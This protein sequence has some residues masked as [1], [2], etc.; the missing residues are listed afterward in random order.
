MPTIDDPFTE[1]SALILVAALLGVAATLLRQPLIVA[2]IIVGIVV[3][4]SAF[5]L[6]QDAELW[7][8]LAATGIS[9]LLFVVGLRLDLDE[10]RRTGPVAL[11]TGLGQVFFTSVVGYGIATLL[12]F[13]TIESLYIAVALTFSS[14]II[15]VKLLSDKREIDSLHGRIAVGFLIVQDIVV[16]LV[17]IGIS[18]F[19]ASDSDTGPWAE[20]L[21]VVVKGVALLGGVGLL[22]RFV[23]PWIFG[24]LAKSQELLVLGAVG[25]AMTMALTGDALGFSKE[26]GAFLAGVALASTPYRDAIGSRLAPLRDFLLLFFFITLGAS[27][28]L[29]L[30]GAQIV[31]AV[32]LSVFVLVGN[33]LIVV[34]IM[35]YMGYRRRTGFLAGLTVAQIS[36]F[37]LILGALGVAIGHIDDET[38]GLITLVGLITIGLS[39]YL[40]LYSHPI[41]DRIEG[42]LRPFERETPFREQAAER[43][44]PTSV[45]VIVFGIGRYG[46]RIAR[47]LHQRG[48]TVLGVDFDPQVVL[49]RTTEDG[50]AAQYGDAEDPE[51]PASLPLR[52]TRW[53]ISSLPDVETNLVLLRFLRDRGYTESIWLTAHH[54]EDTAILQEAG[55]D[56]VLM[57]FLDAAER[58]A[59]RIVASVHHQELLEAQHRELEDAHRRPDDR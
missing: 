50:F 53:V 29:D 13:S 47:V 7:E 42:Y 8:V 36:E 14:T 58:A 5:D 31:P 27:L 49:A 1:F 35:G 16:V 32:I 19:G 26:V 22:A 33:P 59:S 38:L 2:F 48:L 45:D 9:L 10:V 54:D 44:S 46:G 6:I 4:P 3:G 30:L 37:S 28:Q 34:L 57:P 15:I 52:S 12:G 21:W 39:T 24:T 41:Y 20:G 23:L 25:W 11:S 56:L 51:F 40:I 17:M 55:A 18:A 43:S